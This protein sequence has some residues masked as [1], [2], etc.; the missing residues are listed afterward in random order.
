M[1]VGFSSCLRSTAPLMRWGQKTFWS[2]LEGTL[3]HESCLPDLLS[4]GFDL[5]EARTKPLPITP[6]SAPS[7]TPRR[8]QQHQSFWVKTSWSHASCRAVG[9]WLSAQSAP[10]SSTCSP[11]RRHTWR[12]NQS[13]CGLKPGLRRSSNRKTKPVKGNHWKGRMSF[14]SLVPFALPKKG[15]AFRASAV[16]RTWSWQGASTRPA[17]TAPKALE[18]A[19]VPCRLLHRPATKGLSEPGGWGMATGSQTALRPFQTKVCGL[20]FGGGA[21]EGPVG[22]GPLLTNMSSTKPTYQMVDLRKGKQ[23]G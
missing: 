4:S 19:G 7:V 14:S 20:K 6:P 11:L 15:G 23:T 12:A 9:L 16:R 1:L 5:A 10:G 21:W 22:K 8:M 2:P 18:P 3:Q 13:A 17:S